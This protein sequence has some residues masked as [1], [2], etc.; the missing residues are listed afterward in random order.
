[1]PAPTGGGQAA[2]AF[3]VWMGAEEAAMGASETRTVGEAVRF[4]AVAGTVAMAWGLGACGDDGAHTHTTPGADAGAGDGVAGDGVT[5]DG[6]T[7]GGVAVSTSVSVD[8]ATAGL[9]SQFLFTGTVTNAATAG[10]TATHVQV[11]LNA[12][13]QL[14]VMTVTPS[15]GS[16]D[17]VSR[18][19]T[20]DA[21]EPGAFEMIE[22]MAIPGFEG[23]HDLELALEGV[24]QADA[25]QDDDVS[26]AQITV[27]ESG[28]AQT[29]LGVTLA[30]NTAQVTTIPAEVELTVGATNAGPADATGVTVQLNV[31]QTGIELVDQTGDGT[32]DP[33]QGHWTVPSLAQA[34][35][36]TAVLRLRVTRAGH[37]SFNATVSGDQ[38]DPKFPNNGASA[39]LDA[40]AVDLGV[41]LQPDETTFDAVPAVCHLTVT[42]HNS[43]QIP[44]T[45]AQVALDLNQKGLSVPAQSGDGTYDAATGVWSV[46]EVP[47]G[48]SRS[49]VLDVEVGEN[50]SWT[51][52]ATVSANEPDTS[53]INDETQTAIAAVEEA[54]VAMVSL[55]TDVT[56]LTDT[57]RTFTVTVEV[58][59]LGP[60]NAKGVTVLLGLGDPA[61]KLN[62][63]SGVGTYDADTGAWA[64]GEL[65]KDAVEMAQIAIDV[66]D[67]GSWEVGA[68]ASVAQID[69]DPSNNQA[70]P[71]TITAPAP[72][73]Q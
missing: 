40:P 45:G 48:E 66:K 52:H 31:P 65:A 27:A 58:T 57:Q 22:V 63:F 68:S 7:A 44:A 43:G 70:S 56:D 54:D 12:S 53:V 34:S 1:M 25:T 42:V 28:A 39:E 32:F 16:Y 69:P 38:P 35:S 5:G 33:A 72:A 26:D 61:F 14:G 4:L 64:V 46:G 15:A 6:A 60:A 50:G 73:E 17:A 24:D 41:Q 59:N 51:I 71:F 47:V 37:W 11:R 62:S 2:G 67:E 8:R 36:A 30:L 20:V 23:V 21:L 55:S 13:T 29:D 9:G 18:I 49:A 10:A 3:D 19:W